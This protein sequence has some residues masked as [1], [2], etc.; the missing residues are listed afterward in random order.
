MYRDTF[1]DLSLLRGL[2]RAVTDGTERLLGRLQRFIH[3]LLLAQSSWR[4]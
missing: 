2:F 1:W 4:Y 3:V